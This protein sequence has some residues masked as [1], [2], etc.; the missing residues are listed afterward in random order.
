M[1]NNSSITENDLSGMIEHIH[2]SPY[3]MV[4]SITG[5]GTG[6]IGEV[7]RHG[8]GSATLIEA[9][10][11]YHENA[12]KDFIGK[13]PDKYCSGET[14]R[15][16]AMVAF[17]R[18]LEMTD[19]LKS[20][21]SEDVIGMGATCKLAREGERGDRRHEIHFASQSL[22][23]TTTSSLTLVQ[24]RT[25]EEEE[26]MA[27]MFILCSIAKLCEVQAI[28]PDAFIPIPEQQLLKEKCSSASREIGQMLSGILMDKDRSYKKSN[29]VIQ[30]EK[31]IPAGPRI[32]FAGSFNPFHKNH[33]DMAKIA[34]EKYGSP[35]VF[36][37]SLANVDKPPIDF[38]SLESR[39]H[40]LKTYMNEDFFGS[41][42]LTDAPL[43]AE[44]AVLFPDSRFLVG[45]D[46]L[47]RIFNE[48]YYRDGENRSSL[49]EHFRRC[50]IRFLIFHR[51][52]VELSIEEDVLGI[53]DIM[54]HD[55]YTDDGTS[56][57]QLRRSGSL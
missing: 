47:N 44:K 17:K 18:A 38:I 1:E 50:N 29:I 41:I 11:P 56:S 7:L 6:T 10:V 37:I 21:R 8:R 24:D 55:T 45:Y 39:I 5:G 48:R 26:D 51:Q 40:S 49:L 46:T 16:M 3:M 34:Y 30:E 9:I 22:L 14:A 33:A 31:G 57:T 54:P 27:S 52:D 15:E 43:F 2:A 42:C 19:T 32:I 53:C 35:V 20:I 13:E 28:S 36:E 12:L 4:L 25:R 23:R